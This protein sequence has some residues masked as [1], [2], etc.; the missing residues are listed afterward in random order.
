[1]LEK[2]QKIAT[3]QITGGFSSTPKI[4]LDCIAGIMPIEIKLNNI[5][6]KTAIRLFKNK[7]W[8][9]DTN[10]G[11]KKSYISHARHLDKE[12]SSLQ[13]YL[14]SPLHEYT[15]L[16]SINKNFSLNINEISD[17]LHIK[18]TSNTIQ[19]F[20]DGSV[21]KYE[22][23]EQ[24][25]AGIFI[26]LG[27]ISILEKHISL[28]TMTTINQ[29]EL[30]AMNEAAKFLLSNN[31]EANKIIFFTD[32]LNS[33]QKLNQTETTSHLTI[34][35]VTSLNNLSRK[36]NEILIQKV[37]AHDGIYGNEKA[38]NLGKIPFNRSRT[39]PLPTQQPTGVLSHNHNEKQ[40]NNK[41]K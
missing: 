12:L 36:Y 5:A 24:A 2:V 13:S 39:F 22:S 9:P 40:K 8:Y 35:T 21:L 15:Q 17:P 28:G 25:G 18:P 6:S 41:D 3:L 30:L 19:I 27:H 16:T 20:T 37:K 38:H 34:E 4:T 10:I 7:C 29:A 31:F 14:N 23:W 1:M 11:C 32:S 26:R 33:I